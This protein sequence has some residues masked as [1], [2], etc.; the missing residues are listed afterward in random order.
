M[1]ARIYILTL[2]T[3]CVFVTFP[4]A[5]HAAATSTVITNNTTLAPGEYFFD[6]LRV[7]SSSTLT[8][9]GDPSRKGF[10]GVIIHANNIVVDKGSSI[11]ADAQGYPAGEGPGAPSPTNYR[12]GASYGGVGIGNTATSTY[13]SALHPIDLG[14]GGYGSGGGAM[15][16]I[17]AGMIQNDGRISADGYSASS[18][19]S[20]YV[21][22]HTLTG[23][24]VFSAMGG[25]LFDD[26]SYHFPGGGGRILLRY[27]TSSFSGT[28]TAAGQCAT[29]SGSKI[30]GGDGTVGMINTSGNT[31]MLPKAWQFQ[32][33]KTTTFT[34]ILLSGKQITSEP[35]ATISATNFTL[36]NA[37]NVTLGDSVHLNATNVT[38]GGKST[39]SIA[40]ATDTTIRNLDISG[41]SKLT[42]APEHR[43][44]LSLTDLTVSNGSTIDLSGKGYPARE[45][46]G[47]AHGDQYAGASYGG[48][49]Y[50]NSATSTY[51][52]ADNPTDFGS[53][54]YRAGGGAIALNIADTLTNNGTISVEGDTSGSGGSILVHTKT[55]VGN[56]VFN[57]NGGG[58]GSAIVSGAGGG[59]RIALYA[60]GATSTFTGTIVANGYCNTWVGDYY[61]STAGTIVVKDTSLPKVPK[62]SNVLFLPGIEGSTLY[63]E[64][65]HQKVWTPASDTV[66]NSLKLNSDGTSIDQNIAVSKVISQVTVHMVY[67]AIHH[68]VYKDLLQEMKNWQ[69]K[70]HIIATSTPYDWRLGYNTL[71]TKGR[72]LADGHISYIEA[73]KPGH[74]PYIIETLKHLASTSP[75]GK[76]TIIAHSNG[77]LLAKALMQ[78]LGATTTARLI[79]NVIL[80]AT[81]QLG[82]PDAIGVLLNGYGAGIPTLL[83]NKKA[84][85]LAQNMP[86]TYDL[87]P[88]QSYFSYADNFKNSDNQLVS[89]PVVTISS[90]TLPT[91]SNAYGSNINWAQGL[92][93]FMT[94]SA[95]TRNVPAYD[96]LID[97]QIANVNL[98]HAA[99]ATHASLDKWTPPTSVHLYTIAGWGNE[100]VAGIHY[101]KLPFF[102]CL[103]FA[104][105]SKVWLSN[106]CN[107]STHISYIPRMVMDGDGTVVT[108]SALWADGGKDTRYWVNLNKY[109]GWLRYSKKADALFGTHH[110]NIF[111]VSELRTLLSSIITASTTASLP[112]YISTSTPAYTGN[113][114]RLHFILHSPLTLGFINTSGNYTGA[115]ATSTEFNIPGVDYRRFGEVQWLSVP[116]SMTGK[117]VMRGIGSGSFALDIKEQNGNTVVAST[118]FAAIP[119]AT[120]TIA[121]LAI[122]PATD[123]TASSTLKVNY[124]GDGVTYT[125]YNAKQGSIVIPDIIPPEAIIGFSTST[126]SIQ[127]TGID[128]T[129]STTVT[130]TATSTTITDQAGN[131]LT[132]A[133]A[134]Y[135]S[136]S[137]HHKYHKIFPFLKLDDSWHKDG[138]SIERSFNNLHIPNLFAKKIPHDNNHDRDYRRDRKRHHRNYHSK[139]VRHSFGPGFAILTMRSLSYSNGTTTNATA[140]L[141]Y[142]W[143]TN[144]Q[145]N[146]TTLVSDIKTPTKNIVATYFPRLNKT[147]VISSAHKHRINLFTKPHFRREHLKT[148]NGLYV[149]SVKTEK[150]FVQIDY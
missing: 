91:W 128:E 63:D 28:V 149:P 14:S 59:G 20:I 137:R 34:N 46:P 131:W 143:N 38:L 2:L 107:L 130:S 86:M 68:T 26:G 83:S 43:L 110:D 138:R 88:S 90:S 100:T 79:D 81:P 117:V 98:L 52:S 13:G 16:L 4:T 87:L 58:G 108:P 51:G 12:S 1:R 115:T 37:S 24:G 127:I 140:T 74:D 106:G 102:K 70:Y 92:Y 105:E 62:V 134:K 39:L 17:V 82:T 48:I 7:A 99:K 54:G 114:A 73:P 85:D 78:K 72:K 15:Q 53:G 11:S 50:R 21:T 129:S 148:Y 3:L 80:I 19:G 139:L 45:G 97:P 141:H 142:F 125:Q 60:E 41:S 132:I 49:G 75:T 22:T 124:S 95:G 101:E 8:L 84:R 121:T 104:E 77:G 118:T 42:T 47:T 116:Q 31:L 40:D 66:A 57:A 27:A 135:P 69:S 123:P 30:C 122:N 89:T 133:T 56:G 44:D 112:K 67:K 9:Q 55:L 93:N 36:S 18:G 61:C 136:F 65:I 6:T 71:I 144:R 109:N 145:G 64:A 103:A 76:V 150:G 113:M 126:K 29:P 119:S 147:Y 25:A 35:G 146:Y 23:T 120:S 33:N 96:D 10:K 94:D 111:N 5:T 32:S